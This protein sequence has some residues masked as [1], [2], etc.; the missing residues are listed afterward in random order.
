MEIN[1][2]HPAQHASDES[3]RAHGRTPGHGGAGEAHPAMAHRGAGG[4]RDHREMMRQMLAKWI[5]RAFANI[6]LGLWLLSASFTFGYGSTAVAW[7]DNG[8]SSGE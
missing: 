3:A 4:T 8:T 7:K 1:E 6:I 2:F 5:W